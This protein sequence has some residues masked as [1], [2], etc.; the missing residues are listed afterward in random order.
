MKRDIGTKLKI[1]LVITRMDRGGAPDI[2]KALFNHLEAS[3]HEVKLITGPTSAPSR[4]IGLFMKEKSDEIIIIPELKRDPDPVKDLAALVRLTALFRR[5]RFDIVH[6]HTA[7]AGFIGRIAARLGGVPHVVHTPHGHNFYGYFSPLATPLIVVLERIAA[8][9]SDRIVV[10]TDVEKADM[11]RYNICSASKLAVV[12]SG[13]DLKRYRPNGINV[14][15]KRAEF[16]VGLDDRLVGMIGRLE[17]VK[18]SGYFIDAVKVV[19]EKIP[20]AKFLIVG[21]GPL[22]G[23]L[24]ARSEELNIADRVIFTGWRE[25]IPEILAVLDIVVLASL[26]EAV[27]RVLLEA[28]AAGK[29]VVA[30]NVGGIPEILKD[31][32]TGILVPPG[33]SGRIADA[34]VSLL[35]DSRRMRGMGLAAQEWVNANFDE[36]RMVRDIDALYK[37]LIKR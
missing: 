12:P 16:K 33:D 32:E 34:L 28:G 17:A 23:E 21:D 6:T 20:K 2:V 29:V 14:E 35:T 5:D 1:A 4:E 18:G 30:T 10:L 15:G 8:K 9:F 11:I 37:E 19:A 3:E 31:N 24:K 7:K 22:K 13:L 25:D 36:A 27:G 26:N